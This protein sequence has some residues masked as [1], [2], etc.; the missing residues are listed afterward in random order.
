MTTAHRNSAIVRTLG[1]K[2]LLLLYSFLAAF[3]EGCFQAMGL[4]LNGR[5]VQFILDAINNLLC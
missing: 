3:I 4:G 5:K 1:K 2:N